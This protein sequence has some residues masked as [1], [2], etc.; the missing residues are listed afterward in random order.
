[1]NY[2]REKYAKQLLHLIDNQQQHLKQLRT[3]ALQ[4]REAVAHENLC[5]KALT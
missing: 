5:A 4:M 2:D 3:K 1:M